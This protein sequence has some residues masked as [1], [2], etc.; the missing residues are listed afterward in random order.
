MEHKID[1]GHLKTFVIA[2]NTLIK[3]LLN[4]FV[5]NV[6]SQLEELRGY[7]LANDNYN[8]SE[9]AHK[10]KSPFLYFGLTGVAERLERIEQNIV[11][12]PYNELLVEAE[13]LVE[14]GKDCAKQALV[15]IQDLT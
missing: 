12:I 5:T 15:Y 2:D 11:N 13:S 10:L 9:T 4:S 6:P 7:I 3:K 1:I 14:I 8:A